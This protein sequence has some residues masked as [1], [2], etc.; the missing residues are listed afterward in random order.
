[1][2]LALLALVP[3]RTQAQK[4]DPAALALATFDSAWAR[5]RAFHYDST[6]GGMDWNAV[7]T[8]L[9]PQVE[10]APGTEQ[11]RRTIRE[12]ISRLG[13]SHY[14]L[15]PREVGESLEPGHRERSADAVPADAGL[16]LRAV[17]SD[18]VV[19]RVDPESP[20]AVLGLRPGARVLGV[21]KY[22][23]VRAL[24]DVQS[25]SDG[26]ERQLALTRFLYGVNGLLAGQGGDTVRVVLD[27]AGKAQVVAVPL[28]PTPGRL[29]RFGNVPPSVASVT[30]RREPAGESCVGVIRW[31][32]WLAPIAADIDRAVDAVRDCRGIVLDLRGNPGGVAGMVMGI[33][34]HFVDST[35]AL[36]TMK[37]RGNTLR[38]VINPRRVD[39]RGE[40]VAI[41]E[42]RLAILTDA[43][44]AS[45]SEIF[46]AGMQAIGR[47][48][49]FGDITAGQALPALAA[50]LPN[51]DVLMHAVADYLV[52]DQGRV[53]GKGVIPDES[54]PL[55]IAAV[56]AGK[57]PALEAARRW[58]LAPR[59]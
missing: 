47:A 9:R 30:Y 33:G 29:V 8:E 31:T 11:V 13:V 17:G 49:V 7:R 32:I 53:E 12:M 48:R 38:F 2:L 36:G 20:A 19:W 57:D 10:R 51:G 4:T 14:A 40:A 15:I 58:I 50:R 28:R 45:T 59:D 41:Y 5:V 1:M 54:A 44:S 46:A 26:R 22:D 39:A 37:M 16:E 3:G 23:V 18:V 42:G 55:T 43:M 34:G 24:A 21:E 6:F 27:R 35:R 56:R 25:L 52:V